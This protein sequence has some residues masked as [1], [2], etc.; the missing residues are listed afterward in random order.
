MMPKR[1][2]TN[3]FLMCLTPTYRVAY[4]PKKKNYLGDWF[5]VVSLKVFDRLLLG[6]PPV[7]GMMQMNRRAFLLLICV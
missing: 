6:Q 2:S 5:V 3:P 7:L 4:P 1:E